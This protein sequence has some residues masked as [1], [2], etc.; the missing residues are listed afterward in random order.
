MED[1]TKNNTF[2][3]IPLTTSF[4]TLAFLRKGNKIA[5]LLNMTYVFCLPL[6]WALIYRTLGLQI[7]FLLSSKLKELLSNFSKA[8]IIIPVGGGYL[9][10]KDSI[11]DS[12]NLIFLLLPLVIGLIL[13]KPIILHS[14]SIGPFGNQFQRLLIKFVLN[15]TNHVFVREETTLK[16]LESIG[17]KKTLITQAPDAA[18]L[19]KTNKKISLKKLGIIKGNHQEVVGITVRKWLGRDAQEKYEREIAKFTDYITSKFNMYVVFIPQVTVHLFEDDDRIVGNK[20]YQQI[21]RKGSVKVL[22]E[23]YSHYE[24]KAI[25]QNL[26]YLVGTRFHSVIFSL[27]SYVPAIAIEYEHKTSGIMK[28]LELAEWVIK[29]EDANSELLLNKFN[30]LIENRKQYLSTLNANLPSYIKKA[31]ATMILVKDAYEK[32]I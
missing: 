9:R 22:N 32:A 23:S 24:L 18:F 5:K 17:V 11:N 2:D 25:Y 28:D 27:T 7:N 21:K 29:I 16:I 20:I 13:K 6:L 8:N 1:I 12:V 10:G 4:I 3:N 14:Q 31:E 15:R 26:D 30:K 19:F